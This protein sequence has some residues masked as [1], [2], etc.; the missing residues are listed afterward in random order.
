MKRKKTQRK[1]VTNVKAFITDLWAIDRKLWLPFFIAL[2]TTLFVSQKAGGAVFGINTDLFEKP[3]IVTS[4]ISVPNP[5]LYPKK[6]TDVPAP[7]VTAQSAIVMDVA[8]QVV[9]YQKN[10]DIDFPLAST[11]KIMTAFVGMDY[12]GES[13]I[14]TVPS[15]SVEGAKMKLVAGERITFK[16]LLYGLLLASGNDA[17][18]TIAHNAPAGLDGFVSDMNEKA[19][20]LHLVSTHYEDPTGLSPMNQT[21]ALDLARLASFALTNKTFSNIVSTKQMR[22]MDAS[23]RHVH[24]LENLNRLLSE[25]KGVVGV[26]T[27]YTEEAGQVLVSAATRDEH[28]IVTVVLKSEDRFLDSQKLL[29]W[30]FA[31]HIFTAATLP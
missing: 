4:P 2:L 12:F 3:T 18:M 27:G 28:T 17:A 8:S 11:T 21:T 30:V 16:N 13:D 9:L 22:V 14:L 10:E 5:A 29:E 1:R 23:G 15:V 25:V 26:K 20:L 6:S 7:V 19:N 31:N 24:N